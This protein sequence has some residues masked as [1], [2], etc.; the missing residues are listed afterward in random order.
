MRE[1]PARR[2]IAFH[3]GEERFEPFYVAEWY[4]T[5]P[6]AESIGL[7][8]PD[9]VGAVLD[10]LRNREDYGARW[11]AFALLGLNNSTLTKLASALR[12]LGTRKAEGDRTLR[13]MVREGSVVVN[14]LAH[15][16]LSKKEFFQNVTIRARMEHYRAKAGTTVSIGINQNSDKVI[17]VAQ[18]LEGEWEYEEEL[19]KMLKT[20]REKPR[21]MIPSFRSKKPGRNDP[22]PC[23]SGLKFKR[24]C[25]GRIRFTQ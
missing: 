4:G 3:G 6:P 24:C 13:I 15:R 8:V 22:C 19:E 21:N 2:F 23:G 16:G 5:T 20:D 11:I 7:D 25:M 12:E 9:E 1:G 18:W 10:E 17:E 14:V